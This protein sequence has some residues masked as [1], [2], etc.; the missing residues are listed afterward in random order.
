MAHHGIKDNLL[1]LMAALLAG[2]MRNIEER[3]LKQSAL[4]NRYRDAFSTVPNIT[5][6]TNVAIAFRDITLEAW[7]PYWAH[8]IVDARAEFFGH[9]RHSQLPRGPNKA[10][11]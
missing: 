9:R 8:L 5:L 6:V 4:V 11:L 3:C 2:Q 7:A 10:V 1:D